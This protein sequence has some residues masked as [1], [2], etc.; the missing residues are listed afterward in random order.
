MAETSR[1]TLI[2]GPAQVEY[3]TAAEIG[4]GTAAKF[5]TEGDVVVNWRQPVFERTLAIFGH[6]TSR[7]AD[8]FAEISFTHDGEWENDSKLKLWPYF[9]T[10]PGTSIF[11]A[12]GSERALKISPINGT[13]LTFH[14]TAVTQMPP[15]I[16]SGVKALIGAVQFTALG[17]DATAWSAAASY[18]TLAG[19]GTITDFTGY[20]EAAILTQPYKAAWGA[21]TGFTDL[22]TEEGFVWTPQCQFQN[23]RL[24]TRGTQ[25][26]RFMRADSTLAAKLVGPTEDELIAATKQQGSGAIIGRS[27]VTDA[28]DF[29]IKAHPAGTTFF[30]SKNM[31]LA[32]WS[33]GYGNGNRF[34]NTLFKSVRKTSGSPPDLEPLAVIV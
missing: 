11:G 13:P 22:D 4:A 7:V 21:V 17:I 24:D 28:N 9:S 29:V 32:E 12:P 19:T 34:A 25:D 20:S 8:R 14:N 1:L 18:Y 6:M 16:F 15:I 33:W 30:T 5:Y 27:L 31:Y 10:K 23:F 3:G 26:M 2:S